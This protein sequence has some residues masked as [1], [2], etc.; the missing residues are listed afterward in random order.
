LPINAPA[1]FRCTKVPPPEAL[2]VAAFIS[3]CA[4]IVT[5]SPL[6][7]VATSGQAIA[8]TA[9]IAPAPASQWK[10]P[11]LVVAW[12]DAVPDTSS[13]DRAPNKNRSRLIPS[14]SLKP[15]QRNQPTTGT[16][17]RLSPRPNG[18]SVVSG[19]QT[20]KGHLSHRWATQ[21]QGRARDRYQ[22]RWTHGRLAHLSLAQPLRRTA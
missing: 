13:S 2:P 3:P 4:L 10:V 8:A 7:A 16:G 11:V 1:E 9:Q 18:E 5:V 6:L 17:N 20:R 12:A 22:A 19:A 21:R 15:M 14:S